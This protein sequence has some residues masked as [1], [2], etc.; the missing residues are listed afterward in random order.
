MHRDTLLLVPLLASIACGV[1]PDS[2][3]MPAGQWSLQ[4]APSGHAKIATR[5]LGVPH[6][7]EHKHEEKHVEKTAGGWNALVQLVETTIVQSEQEKTGTSQHTEKWKARSD[8]G[9]CSQL[10]KLAKFTSTSLLQVFGNAPRSATRIASLEDTLM[11]AIHPGPRTQVPNDD[12][13][14]RE[15]HGG[16]I[17]EKQC[18]SATDVLRNMYYNER[19][20]ELLCMVGFFFAFMIATVLV[21]IWIGSSL[22]PSPPTY[23]KNGSRLFCSCRNSFDVEVDVTKKLLPTIQRLFDMTTVPDKMGKGL[24]GDWQTHKHFKVTKVIRIENGNH[25]TQYATAMNLTSTF[26]TSLAEIPPSLKSEIADRW[27]NVASG[28]EERDADPLVGPFLKSLK[29]D[30]SKNEVMLFHGSPLA[31]ARNRNGDV[32]FPT[33]AQ[34]PMNAIKKTG[35]DERLGNVKGMLGSGTYFG[36]HVSKSD[37]YAGRYHEWQD[38]KDPGSVGEQA[39]MFLARVCL[40]TPYMTQQSLE[41]LRR[42]PCLQGHFDANLAGAEVHFG[43]PWKKKGVELEICEHPRFDSVISDTVIDS[44]SNFGDFREYVLYEK[45]CYPEFLIYYERLSQEE[46]AATAAVPAVEAKHR[47]SLDSTLT[48]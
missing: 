14:K 16:K 3:E 2:D 28:F 21:S 9:S 18:E 15:A 43:Q 30:S 17:T 13:L 12:D 6:Q 10:A 27:A 39:A 19:K 24:D 48:C 34:A 5:Q 40:G 45:K 32:I 46:K 31:G 20:V 36:D 25:W 37:C 1:R 42:P 41:Q 11:D 22:K 26:Q 7:H 38:G 4:L 44:D 47:V 35:F 23:W 8:L 29:L 33:E